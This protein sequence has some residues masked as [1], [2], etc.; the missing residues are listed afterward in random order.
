MIIHSVT[1]S[2][3]PMFPHDLGCFIESGN[4]STLTRNKEYL[5]SKF[6][7]T[8]RDSFKATF[9]CYSDE[10]AYHF[11]E[12]W[13]NELIY[14][15]KPFEIDIVQFGVDETKVATMQND[16]NTKKVGSTWLFPLIIEFI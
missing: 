3:M 13:Q 11:K 15:Q 10:D 4:G 5:A 14:G 7:R 16:L 6:E 9:M 1:T 12:W 8:R 2:P